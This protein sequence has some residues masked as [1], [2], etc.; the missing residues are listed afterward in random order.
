MQV[1]S[2]VFTLGILAGLFF[3]IP[4][5]SHAIYNSEAAWE[6]VVI[7]SEP[8]CSGYHYY[9]MEKFNDISENYLEL[10][11]LQN[12]GYAP[13]CMTEQE[14]LTEYEKPLDLDLLIL[15]YDRDLGRA[16]LHSQ[17]TGGMYIHQ[18]DD[19][20][21]NHTI[22]FCDCPNFEYSDPV[23][24]LSHELSH[25]VLN[26]LGFDLDITEDN[27]HE[28]DQKFDN[29]VE[30][31]YDDS[32]LSV[33]TRMETDR[34]TWVVMA[35]YEPA[36]GKDVPT[37]SSDNASFDSFYQKE[38]AIEVTNWW[39]Q[40]DIT[41]ENYVKSLQ[42]LSGTQTDEGIKSNGILAEPQI[43][44]LTEPP[45]ENKLPLNIENYSQVSTNLLSKSPFLA[46]ENETLSNQEEDALILLVKSKAESWSADSINDEEFL[47]DLEYILNSPKIDLYQNNLEDL[48]LE[49]LIDK[50]IEFQQAGEYRNSI[51]Y[52]D[53]ALA[54]GI[55]SEETKMGLLI[56]MG[57][58]LNDLTQYEEALTYF[59]AVLD[60]EPENFEALNRK[61]FTLAQL[62]EIDEAEHYFNLYQK[63]S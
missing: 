46:E 16:S 39:L 26:Y 21:R 3:L 45:T 28:L 57:S 5:Q 37:P 60:V 36:I 38:M 14:Y 62:G 49:E 31:S 34:A 32:C 2:L 18:G 54:Q 55:D 22:I 50:G 33:K 51:S 29:C 9:M 44:V 6:L 7:S 42:I 25:F 43:T 48:S 17:N 27:I 13:Q 35:P 61:A 1:W 10:Y 15:V 47:K 58:A 24:I 56:L 40:G 52:F 23:W 4:G 63:Y 41:N 20:S 19:L 8:A 53:H 12:K 11:Q 59:D 30:V